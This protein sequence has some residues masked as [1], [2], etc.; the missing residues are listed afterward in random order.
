[1][2]DNER[3]FSD[4]A[5]NANPDVT[6]KV[7]DEQLS[8]AAAEAKEALQHLQNNDFGDE[9]DTLA[10][11]RSSISTTS[12]GGFVNFL[13]RNFFPD[14]P[15]RDKTEATILLDNTRNELN[16]KVEEAIDITPAEY[17]QLPKLDD[18]CEVK[19][20]F[21]GGGQGIIS[22][23]V[24]KSLHRNIA[25]KSLR[26]EILD[27]PALRNAFVNEAMITAQLEHP[28]IIPVHGLFGDDQNGLH[29]AMKLVKGHTLKDELKRFI[30]LRKKVGPKISQGVMN[31]L[32]NERIDMLLRVCDAVA[33]AHS[34]NI[35]HCD[36]KPENIM[37]GEYG[38]IY[39]MDWGLARRFRDANGKTLPNTPGAPL[40]GTPRYM[41]AETFQGQPRD[42][43]TDIF[44]LGLILFEMITLRH[45]YNGKSIQEVIQKI[46]NGERLPVVNRFGYD[47][48]PDLVA[49][50]EKATAY[51][52]EERYQHVNDLTEDLKR[53]LGGMAVSARP[54]NFIGKFFRGI[55]RYSR[56]LVLLTLISWVISGLFI[57]QH[58]K[59]VNEKAKQELE[60]KNALTEQL[61]QDNHL[62]EFERHLTEMDSRVIRSAIRLSNILVDLACDLRNMSVNTGMLLAAPNTDTHFAPDN[63]TI[64]F[65]FYQQ[66]NSQNGAEYSPVY[67]D[68]IRPYACSYQFPPGHDENRIGEELIRLRPLA[69]GLQNLVLNSSDLLRGST[70]SDQVFSIVK[71]GVL[72]RRAYLGLEDTHLHLAYPAS[73]K[74]PDDYD[75]HEREWYCDAKAQALSKFQAYAKGKSNADSLPLL[76]PIWGK[77]YLDA[78]NSDDIK[79]QLVLTCSIPIVSPDQKT[80]LGVVAFDLFFE[81][82][83]TQL[84]N[85]GNGDA[86]A[87]IE[88]YLCSGD[89]TILCHVPIH[90]IAQGNASG[91]EG[92]NAPSNEEI[93]AK[94]KKDL[95]EL[96]A[97]DQEHQQ[98]G[99]GHFKSRENKLGIYYHYAYIPG[100]NLFLIEKSRE[101]LIIQEMKKQEEEFLRALQANI[102][103]PQDDTPLEP[104]ED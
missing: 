91:K 92:D 42:E 78:S 73:G 94:L 84:R 45:G 81:T 41:P 34:R 83:A 14:L 61:Q 67:K 79:K 10:D 26:K 7:T 56:T 69:P 8:Q 88:K 54:E 16:S 98:G 87:I 11:T 23:A 103:A 86:D 37:I 63:E 62:L 9:D 89:G 65:I 47:L 31:R 85:N 15:D 95:A 17:R 5:K 55:R 2:A 21:A 51:L 64:P 6:I 53:Y 52:P 29:Q 80:F 102:A 43:R 39:V 13:H 93:E 30:H 50:V 1:M 18:I 49:I 58:L 38:E 44:A 66:I 32:F 48:N 4:A 77:P 60:D 25:I 68:Y 36:L 71:K 28:A 74:Y 33:Y 57:L 82:F 24:D 40:D 35:I 22:R 46:K 90:P 101:D 99:Y 19:D 27:K 75:N 3:N 104:M 70:S 20:A 100:L 96:F 12:I 59:T 72:V 97:K 76:S